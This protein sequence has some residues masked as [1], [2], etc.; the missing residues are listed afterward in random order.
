MSETAKQFCRPR[1]ASA[2]WLGL[3]KAGRAFTLIEL[4][5]VIAIIAILAALLL[6]A[7]AKAKEKGKNAVDLNNLRQV[8]IGIHVYAI[9]NADLVLS[10][11]LS[12]LY[13]QNCLN[14]PEASS[15]ASVGL[16]VRSNV[17]S[18]WTCPNRPGLPVYE[19]QYPQWVIGY[20]YFGGIASWHNPA[21]D[22]PSRSPVKVSSSKPNWTLAADATMKIN[23]SWGG[24]EPGREF[25]YA[26]MPQHRNGPSMVPKGGHHLLMDGSAKWAKF[27]TMYFLTTWSLS[28]RVAYFYQDTSDFDPA[29]KAQ[30]PSLRAKP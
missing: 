13:V 10:A 29:L 5:V 19:P 28:S 30:L 7:L 3:D 20:Q 22:F 1:A 21:G 25:V 11:R 16:N 4:L 14:P 26:N 8:A 23:G 9:D 2:E 6:P 18:I 15:A 27:E 12:G 24:L 17:A